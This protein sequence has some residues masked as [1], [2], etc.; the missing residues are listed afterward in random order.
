MKYHPKNIIIT[1]ASSGL[2]KALAIEYADKDTNLFLIGRNQARLCIV[3]NKCRSKGANVF[4]NV[5]NVKNRNKVKEWIEKIDKQ[6]TIDLLIAN[7]GISG[8]TSKGNEEEKQIYDIFDTNIY[9]V[10]NAITPVIP[11]MKQQKFG[12]IAIISSMASFRGMPS[13]P[14]YSS[15]KACIRNYGEALYCDLKKY[16]I[17]VSTVC[18]GFI[19]TPL[20]EKNNFI[21]PF[22]IDSERAAIIIKNGLEK[23]KKIIIFPKL[24]YYLMKFVNCLPFGLNDFVFSKLPKK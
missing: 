4:Y 22:K 23:K 12:Q 18:P 1:G 20:T 9:G 13:A 8:G 17:N 3:A 6:Y 10:L 14:S 21:M 11:I 24:L 5:L 2:G 16:N 19:K 7:A 15:T